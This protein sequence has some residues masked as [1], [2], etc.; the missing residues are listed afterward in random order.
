MPNLRGPGEHKRRLY[1]NVVTSIL[2][3]GAP[4]W[5]G[6][7]EASKRIQALLKRLTRTLT[8]RMASAYRIISYEAA[9]LLARIPP[10]FLMARLRKRVYFRLKDLH[11]RN[12][13][14]KETDKEIR[15]IEELILKRQW[16]IHLS[17]TGLTGTRTRDAI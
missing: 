2:T 9:T 4:V 11:R 7:L 6:A 16:Q 12:E 5:S 1:A 15:A 3:Y 14:S 17:N 13:W 8:V 10:L